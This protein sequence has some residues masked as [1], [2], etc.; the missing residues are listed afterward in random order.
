MSRRPS[1]TEAMREAGGGT[2]AAARDE[3]SADRAPGAVSQPGRAATK[4]ITG[5]FAPEVRAQL[6]VLSAEQGRTMEDMMAEA[7]NMLFA[8]YG[9]SE[10]A[11]SGARASRIGA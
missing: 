8:S 5:H 7:F 2:R 9:K 11:V 3:G 6:K 1:I 4:A 10:I